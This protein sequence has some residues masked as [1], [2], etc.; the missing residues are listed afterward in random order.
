MNHR[1]R[2]MTYSDQTCIVNGKMFWMDMKMNLGWI[3]IEELSGMP[4]NAK[5]PQKH[6][7]EPHENHM[8]KKNLRNPHR[9]HLFNP[10]LKKYLNKWL[11]EKDVLD[12]K[13]NWVMK[14]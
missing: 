2:M 4:W 7:Q 11:H 3:L 14:G 8:P 12:K 9:K 5:E 13:D 10:K 6:Q 1:T